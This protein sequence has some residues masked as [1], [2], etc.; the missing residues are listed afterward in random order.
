MWRSAK[1]VVDE[2]EDPANEVLK[3]EAAK[4]N[5]A[6]VVGDVIEI[7]LETKQFGRIAAQAAKHVIR[8]GIREAERERL[9]AEYQSHQNDI[10]TATVLR[11]DPRH[12][13]CN[14]GA[15]RPQRGHPAQERAGPR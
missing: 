9:M 2:I 13:Q 10:I 7:P 3:E 15:G 4:Y 8:Q 12:R 1:T 6:A 5:K 14:A 11:V